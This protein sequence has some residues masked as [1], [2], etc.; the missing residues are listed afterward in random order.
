[1]SKQAAPAGSADKPADQV[2]VR[3]TADKGHRHA[4]NK[5]AKG[6]VIQVSPRDAEII[7]DGLKVGELV[8][9]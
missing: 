3:I 6:A 1:M 8:K 2:A 9:E 4:G 5:H 7:V